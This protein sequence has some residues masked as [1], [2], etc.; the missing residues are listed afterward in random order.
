MSDFAYSPDF[1]LTEQ[2]HFKTLVSQFENFT[3]QRRNVVANPRRLFTLR[4]KN[5][6]KTEMENVRDFFISKKG[7]YSSFT[8]TNPNDETEYTVRF[9]EDSF[10]F[11][12]KAYE[13]Y[14]FEIKFI[15][16]V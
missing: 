15:E 13:V 14:D 16:V 10:Q 11:D 1:T 7:E 5:R 6:T 8:W 2:V 12:N 9:D 4:F 3:E